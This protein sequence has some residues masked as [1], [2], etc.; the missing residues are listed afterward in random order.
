MKGVPIMNDVIICRYQCD[1]KEAFCLDDRG[2][3]ALLSPGVDSDG[4]PGRVTRF[5]AS[6]NA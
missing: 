6:S 5:R 3:S 4:W 2:G 1:A